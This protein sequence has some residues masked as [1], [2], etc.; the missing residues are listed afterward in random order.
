[1]YKREILDVARNNIFD[2][3][4]RYIL[5]LPPVREFFNLKKNNQ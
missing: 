4:D 3:F 2:N 5:T 1:M